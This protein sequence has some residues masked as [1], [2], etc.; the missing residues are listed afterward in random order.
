[1][2]VLVSS[3]EMSELQVGSQVLAYHGPMLYEAR[4]LKVFDPR[5]GKVLSKK[6]GRGDI[7][8]HKE[9]DLPLH[10]A[11]G[12]DSA[13]YVHY[14]GW[15]KTWDEWVFEERILPWTD[16]NLE[17]VET[18]K[19]Q[20]LTNP[21]AQTVSKKKR[22]GE[23]VAKMPKKPKRDPTMQTQ[24][25]YMSGPEIQIAMP[26]S[27]KA[28]LVDDWELIT[29]EQRVVPLPRSPSASEILEKFRQARLPALQ[30]QG[31]GPVEILE[32]VVA[33]I[34]LYFDRSLGSLLL[35][36]PERAQYFDWRSKQGNKFSASSLYGAEHLLR[37]FVALP[38]LIA[39]TTMEQEAVSV[40]RKNCEDFLNFLA[41]KEDD[42]FTSNYDDNRNASA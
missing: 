14:K 28:R 22:G 17:L 31:T 26:A 39:Q 27:L 34:K 19:N 30:K 7:V 36:R 38:G 10:I 20:Y 6:S 40:L 25:E 23:K 33:G 42:F 5:T 1:M 15:K 24:Q 32:E 2:V 37:L 29:K 4:V 11:D 18:L 41:E 21:G 13:Y 8:E 35:Y 12:A 16:E 9:K 3:A